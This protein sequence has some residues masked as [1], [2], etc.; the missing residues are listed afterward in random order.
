MRIHFFRRQKPEAHSTRCLPRTNYPETSMARRPGIANIRRRELYCRIN[1]ADV[2]WDQ[3]RGR[4]MSRGLAWW[5]ARG[6]SCATCCTMW[7]RLERELNF[8]LNLN[9]FPSKEPPSRSEIE[10]ETMSPKAM[11]GEISD[12]MPVQE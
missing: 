6:A 11:G 12:R 2:S 1:Q 10:H 9:P 7:P 4:E 5:I 3:P 8:G